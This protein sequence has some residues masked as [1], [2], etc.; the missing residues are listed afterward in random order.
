MVF[1]ELGFDV[2]RIDKLPT[3]EKL[4]QTEANE[5]AVLSDFQTELV[6]LAA[7]LNGDHT[8]DSY[9]DELPKKMNVAEACLY[10]ESAVKCFLEACDTAIENGEDWE[11]IVK[12]LAGAA[13]TYKSTSRYF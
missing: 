4:R 1:S 9:P 3:P 11:I 5:N 12:V 8:M 13:F 10:V 2:L 7:Q 6:Q